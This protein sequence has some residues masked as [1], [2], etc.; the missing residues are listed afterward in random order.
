MRSES[1]VTRRL[2]RFGIVALSCAALSS[3]A[4]GQVVTATGLKRPQT[5]VPQHLLYR[6]FLAY[7]N[8]L[9]EVAVTLQKQGEDGSDFRDHFQQILGFTATDYAPVR[10]AARRLAAKL[11]VQDEKIKAVIDTGR[12]QQSRMLRGPEE[13]PAPP[14]ELAQL[15]VERDALI[16]HEVA[17]MNAALGAARAAQV[18]AMIEREV[19]P[20]SQLLPMHPPTMHDPAKS[21]LPP[22]PNGVR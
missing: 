7:Q 12:A 22:F 15:Q 17:R 21:S 1:T 6:H 13:L 2:R 4:F 5:P 10:A 9:D 11:K 14:P 19:A 20:H 8:H 18:Q 16:K 3:I